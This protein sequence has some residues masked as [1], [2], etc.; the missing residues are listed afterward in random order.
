MSRNLAKLFK[1]ITICL[2]IVKTGGTIPD[3]VVV[4]LVEKEEL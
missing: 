4:V 3:L 2:V 1:L